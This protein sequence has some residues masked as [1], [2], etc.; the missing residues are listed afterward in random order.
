M[1]EQTAAARINDTAAAGGVLWKLITFSL[2][3]GAFP[4]GSYFYSLNYIWNGNTTFAAIT[5]I[6]AANIVLVSYIVIS[7]LEDRKAQ[8]A[9]EPQPES[10]KNK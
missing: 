4:I 2:L 8:V 7:V 3:L 10:K 5:A 6:V 9:P 1:S